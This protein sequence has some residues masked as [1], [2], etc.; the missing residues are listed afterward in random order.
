MKGEAAKRMP[1]KP[2]RKFMAEA[3]RLSREGM[4]KGKGGPFGAVVV[5]DGKVVGRG[6]N[7]VISGNDPSAHAEI[8]AIRDACGRLKTYDLGG[9]ELYTSCEPC[10]MCLSAA[11]WARVDRIV[12]ANT[13]R[14]AAGIGFGD[15]FIY[16]ELGKPLRGRAL[17][18]TRLKDPSA[19]KVF[20]A[21]AEKPDKKHYGP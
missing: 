8:Q 13:R 19:A 4:R 16:E 12:F 17:S 21:W 3:V 5:R 10:P 1:G 9:C 6:C 20:R 14:E 2:V 7:E 15:A 18:I 11:Y